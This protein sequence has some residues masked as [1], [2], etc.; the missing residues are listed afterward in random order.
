MSNCDFE[1]WTAEEITRF[2]T[3][4]I[5]RAALWGFFTVTTGRVREH[6]LRT[7]PACRE[8]AVVADID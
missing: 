7:I 6:S 5:G 8:I 1:N 3:G 4:V 2:R